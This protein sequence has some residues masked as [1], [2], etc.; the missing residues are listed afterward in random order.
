LDSFT[1]VL[2]DFASLNSILKVDETSTALADDDGKIVDEKYPKTTPDEVFVQGILKSGTVV[3][4][5]F[6]QTPGGKS[7][8]STGI[9][10]IITG[11][12]GEIEVKTWEKQWQMGF[13]GITLKI[14]IGNGEVED[15]D[16]KD[17]NE[18]AY[19][20]GVGLPGTNTARAYEAFA[21]GDAD[22]YPDFEQGLAT[23]RLLDDIRLGHL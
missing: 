4:T 12:E 22:K 13:P 20:S 10:W 19:V 15:V 21:K 11:T 3:S 6:R 16:F 2:G 8:T 14:R 9:H 18:P 17:A 1:H 7:V 23:H 5:N